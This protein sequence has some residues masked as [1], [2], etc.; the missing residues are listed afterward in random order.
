[1]SVVPLL[2]LLASKNMG[3]NYSHVCVFPP[4]N[5]TGAVATE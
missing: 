3:E 4:D 1:M 2:F 5:Y